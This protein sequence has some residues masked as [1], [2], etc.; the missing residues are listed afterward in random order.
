MGA[1]LTKMK[2]TMSGARGGSTGGAVG[3]VCGGD[4]GGEMRRI[5]LVVAL[6]GAAI[7]STRT[8]KGPRNAVSAAGDAMVLP[9]AEMTAEAGLESEVSTSTVMVTEPLVMVMTT[10]VAA[11]PAA[12]ANLAAS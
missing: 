6:S 7:A 8:P 2:L 1:L 12:D 5:G 11:T 3:G 4:G 10:S 9:R